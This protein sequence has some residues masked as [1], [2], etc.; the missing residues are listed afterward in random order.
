MNGRLALSIL[1]IFF[2]LPL[3]FLTPFLKEKELILLF[4]NLLLPVNI[5]VF[6]WLQSADNA[7][8]PVCKQVLQ[9]AVTSL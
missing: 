2:F 4:Q 3:N 5:E 1:F 6:P 9:G 8:V 7:S